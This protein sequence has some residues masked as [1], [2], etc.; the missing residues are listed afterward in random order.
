[1]TSH[2]VASEQKCTLFSLPLEK[3]CIP[4]REF[5]WSFEKL[6]LGYEDVATL[7]VLPIRVRTNPRQVF[8]KV[9]E[10]FFSI[11]L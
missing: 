11:L 4:V 5:G 7:I 9:G 8:F 6:K 3:T 10:S 1:M 2:V